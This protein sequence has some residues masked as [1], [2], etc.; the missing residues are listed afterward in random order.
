MV[1]RIAL[2]PLEKERIRPKTLLTP[3]KPYISAREHTKEKVLSMIRKDNARPGSLPGS[4][5]MDV[6]LPRVHK[7]AEV[8][9]LPY[10][11]KL[12]ENYDKYYF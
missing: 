11:Q 6:V 4:D 9:N 10:K 1:E 3:I 5:S 7:L 2:S 8:P 12:L